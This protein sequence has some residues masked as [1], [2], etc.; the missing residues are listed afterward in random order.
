[1]IRAPEKVSVFGDSVFVNLDILSRISCSMAACVASSGN[2]QT[3]VEICG[4]CAL[5]NAWNLTP[6]VPFRSSGH[7][8]CRMDSNSSHSSADGNVLIK[9]FVIISTPVT[10]HYMLSRNGFKFALSVIFSKKVAKRSAIVALIV[11]TIL[12]FINHGNL[13]FFGNLTPE[14][15][16]KMI[17]TCFVPFSISSVSAAMTALEAHRANT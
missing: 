16:I 10:K 8:V 14:C 17:A 5:R 9:I 3:T 1:M 11:G 13:I 7:F 15:W 2:S 4:A 12:A 6:L